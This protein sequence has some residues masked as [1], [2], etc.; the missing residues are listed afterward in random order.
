MIEEVK[1]ALV[2]MIAEQAMFDAERK[3]R[4]VERIV[5]K[6][7]TLG[8]EHEL[9]V[10]PELCTTGYIP[11]AYSPKYATRFWDI[12]D[13]VSEEMSPSIN[14]IIKAT[15]GLDCVCAF[16]FSEKSRIKYHIYD[17]V[18]LVAEGKLLGVYRKIHPGTEEVHYF[19]P[20]SSA[21]VYKTRIGKIGIGICYDMMFPE[22]ARVRGVKGAEMI[23]FP[24]GVND[25]ASLKL[26]G[27][28]LPVARA[29]E[30]EAFVMFC[31]GVGICE[32]REVKFCLYGES[33]IVSPRGQIIAESTS[34]NEE[35]ITGILK[36][37]ELEQAAGAFPVFRDR[38]PA[39]Y[40]P[41]TQSYY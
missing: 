5:E 15:E 3:K 1:V 17:S 27:K 29:L 31:N 32:W 33:K 38:Q 23:I 13:D 18:A 21:E 30:N 40:G 4:N 37:S 16:G 22:Q 7:R 39:T 19:I 25:Y 9:I 12:S 8:K 34:D 14:D 28:I 11:A 20:G 2:Q 26:M 41:L 6:I 35:I 10:F 36:R 24:S